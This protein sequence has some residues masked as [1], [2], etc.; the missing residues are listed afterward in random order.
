MIAIYGC[1]LL[2]FLAGLIVYLVIRYDKGKLNPKNNKG[3]L[4]EEFL[5]NVREDKNASSKETELH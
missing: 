5:K 3:I 4:L 1:M 2:V